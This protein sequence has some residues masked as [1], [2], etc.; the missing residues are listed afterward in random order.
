MSTDDYQ[1]KHEAIVA[2]AESGTP[3]G[4]SPRARTIIYIVCLAV[5]VATILVCG[6][7][8]IF[9]FMA[10]EQSLQVGGLI[11]TAIGLLSTGLAVG[12]RPTRHGA[13]Q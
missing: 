1:G 4:I 12:Y 9:G 10:A 2:D 13:I 7:G 11:T 5:E 3:P 6:F 8:V